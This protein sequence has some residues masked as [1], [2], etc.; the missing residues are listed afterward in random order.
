MLGCLAI[1]LMPHTPM[2]TNQISITGPNT[3][4]TLAVP[5]RWT[6]KRAMMIAAVIGTTRSLRD[7]AATLRPSTADST[8]MA[9][10]IMLSPRNSDAPKIPSAARTAFVRRGPA[11]RRISVIRAMM[12]PSPWL[13]ARMTSST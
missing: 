3:L 4:A 12:P 9:G 13:S 2:T 6:R 1:P 11:P 7:G 5:R 8:E 10:V